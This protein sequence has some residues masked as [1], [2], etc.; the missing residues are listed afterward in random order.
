MFTLIGLGI[1]VI[2][3]A[4]VIGIYA[5]LD[6]LSRA[7]SRLTAQGVAPPQASSPPQA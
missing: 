4:M 5:K 3:A 6:D 2:V 1:N 7:V